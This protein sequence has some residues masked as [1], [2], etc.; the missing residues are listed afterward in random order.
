MANIIIAVKHSCILL[1]Q[2]QAATSHDP[3]LIK[4]NIATMQG[5]YGIV[6]NT[7]QIHYATCVMLPAGRKIS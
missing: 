3:K 5:Q 1:A 6:Q 7:S 2:R 4:R